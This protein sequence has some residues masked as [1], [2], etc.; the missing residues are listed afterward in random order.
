MTPLTTKIVDFKIEYLCKY[1]AMCP[2]AQ[3]ELFD[4]K[5]VGQTFHDRVPLTL[6]ISV[7]VFP[8]ATQRPSGDYILP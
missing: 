1:G 5:T 6:T 3:I 2:G 7:S 4:E 8:V